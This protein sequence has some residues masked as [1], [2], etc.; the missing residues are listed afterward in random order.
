MSL[1]EKSTLFPES[2]KQGHKDTL[3]SLVCWAAIAN[4]TGG[5]PFAVLQKCN[6]KGPKQIRNA[7]RKNLKMTQV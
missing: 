5:T 3:T 6:T 4:V 1:A 7:N 2:E